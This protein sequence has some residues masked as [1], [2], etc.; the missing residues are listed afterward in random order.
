[1]VDKVEFIRNIENDYRRK[2]MGFYYALMS[3]KRSIE[4]TDFCDTKEGFEKEAGLNMIIELLNDQRK[5]V[6]KIFNLANAF[7][8]YLEDKKDS[9]DELNYENFM[10]NYD[11]YS[12]ED[13]LKEM[14]NVFD[15]I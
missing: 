15:E 4:Y 2:S 1:M 5:I 11:T 3:L 12:D 8:I 7:R 14:K 6:D 10:K 9:F 13:L